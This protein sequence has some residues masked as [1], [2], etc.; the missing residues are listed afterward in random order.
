M[1]ETTTALVPFEQVQSMAAAVA[2]SHLFKAFD[3]P[4]K[5]LVLMMVAQSEGCHP[6]QAVQRYDVIDGKPS[7][8]ADAMLADFQAKGGKVTWTKLSDKEVEGL[9]ESPGLGK[10]VAVCWTIEMAKTAGLLGKNNWRGYPRA[11]LRSRVVSEGIR[12]S[13]P[14]V[15]AGLYTPE[16]VADFD[17]NPPANVNAIP[18]APE[19]EHTKTVVTLDVS[20]VPVDERPDEPKASPEAIKALCIAMND[21]GIR[22]RED[23]LAWCATVIGHPIAT[24]KDLTVAE[25]SKCISAARAPLPNHPEPGASD[26]ELF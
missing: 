16:E 15:V 14:G 7:K 19:P 9:F 6:M 13:M 26:A 20:E 3:T 11:M 24:R 8:K 25:C 22:D 21:A 4:E 10:P 5:A 12:T 23:V 17:A 1:S 2:K 18:A